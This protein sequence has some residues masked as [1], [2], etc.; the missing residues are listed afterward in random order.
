MLTEITRLCSRNQR[1][2]RK[3]AVQR[4]DEKGKRHEQDTYSTHLSK[5]GCTRAGSGP[6]R[7]DPHDTQRYNEPRNGNAERGTVDKCDNGTR[8]IR[9]NQQPRYFTYRTGSTRPFRSK[10]FE[11]A[12]RQWRLGGD[13]D[14]PRYA[15]DPVRRAGPLTRYH[16]SPLADYRRVRRPRGSEQ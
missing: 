10:R 5:L 3:F 16:R 15:N 9:G 12:D 4:G 1:E 14:Q 6:N 8:L 2:K 11:I 13:G 7:Y